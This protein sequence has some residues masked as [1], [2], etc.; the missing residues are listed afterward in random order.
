MPAPEPQIEAYL[1]LVGLL[2]DAVYGGS[3]GDINGREFHTIPHP[4]I[5]VNPNIKSEPNSNGMK[6]VALMC[7]NAFYPQLKYL[8]NTATVSETYK[9][10][11][12]QAALPHR[13]LPPEAQRDLRKLESRARSLYDN[14]DKYRMRYNQVTNLLRQAESAGAASH[15]TADLEAKRKQAQDE[16]DLRGR[17]LDYENTLA[18]VKYYRSMSP[19]GHFQDLI[20]RY[21]LHT[22]PS[23]TM[24]P[25]QA[26]YLDPPIHE[27]N[28]QY[29]G[30]AQF[31]KT[32]KYSELHKKSRHSSWSGSMGLNFGLFKRVSAGASG[33][34]VE[35]Y[36][37]SENTDIELKFEF[38][39]VRVYRPWLVPD[40][41][42]YRYWT[43]KKE[44]GYREIS[45]G[46]N[47]G[48]TEPIGPRGIMP[49]LPTDLVVA[50]NV[51]ISAAFNERERKFIHDT[52]EGSIYGGWGPFSSKGSYKTES[53]QEDVK[54]LFDET[55]LQIA[56]PQII[57]FL[58]TLLPKSPNPDRALPWIGD[59]DFGDRPP[60]VDGKLADL[61]A[62]SL[63]DNDAYLMAMETQNNVLKSFSE[64]IE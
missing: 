7:D 4:G 41:F 29:S 57:G 52:I 26:T 30:W 56:N 2:E 59:Q 34:H 17:K 49:V 63:P 43:Y 50:R 53:S 38:M 51:S 8:P 48:S 44:F 45:S 58:G 64:P 21:A 39:R 20:D 16:W 6:L 62:V 5:F 33:S 47:P 15:V 23:Q 3:S 35:E 12:T 1:K 28:S 42:D 27:W 14:Y 55:T 9:N 54:A 32:F 19:R 60:E 11:I 31:K 25:Y 46:F 40:L 18:S 10:A 22:K 61:H 36:E 24:G 37:K 13:D